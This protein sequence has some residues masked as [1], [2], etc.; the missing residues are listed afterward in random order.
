MK[1]ISYRSSEPLLGV[2]VPP[3]AQINSLVNS[4]KLSYTKRYRY[5]GYRLVVG[6]VLAKDEVGV[7]F[8][9]PAQK[10]W[11]SLWI[12]FIKDKKY[13]L[14]T[15]MTTKDTGK[16]GEDIACE[17]IKKHGYLLIERNYNKKWGEIDII[18]HKDKMVHF[19]EVKS[20]IGDNKGYRP[21]ENVH[22]MKIKRLKRT[23]Q[24]YLLERKYSIDAEFQFHIIAVYMNMKTRRAR[25]N[26]MKNVIL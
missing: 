16:I 7:R 20:V 10:L 4:N 18:A 23:I 19:I 21:E 9:L 15:S 24:T 14:Y 6:H 5:C 2:R 22:E 17:Y 26:Y 25:V 11:I 3:G 13:G 1:W 8:S 12:L